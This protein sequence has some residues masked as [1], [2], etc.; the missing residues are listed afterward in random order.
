MNYTVLHL[1]VSNILNMKIIA[2]IIYFYFMKRNFWDSRGNK[3]IFHLFKNMF[4]LTAW[5]ILH[6]KNLKFSH[7]HLY[8]FLIST[9]NPLKNPMAPPLPDLP[10]CTPRKFFFWYPTCKTS[11][12]CRIQHCFWIWNPK[13]FISN[14]FRVIRL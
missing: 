14:T 6:K 7:T 13:N 5:T 8:I 1:R 10:F 3:S 2:N 12:R 9:K 4:D 11:F